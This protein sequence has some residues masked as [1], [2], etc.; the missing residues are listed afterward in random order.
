LGEFRIRQIRT[1]NTVSKQPRLPERCP[2]RE[3]CSFGSIAVDCFRTDRTVTC[4][5][6]A[7]RARVGSP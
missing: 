5:V 7:G 6:L 1:S 2:L 3:P 4:Q